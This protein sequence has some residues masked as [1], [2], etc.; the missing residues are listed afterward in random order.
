MARLMSVF[1]VIRSPGVPGNNRAVS[2]AAV[3]SFLNAGTAPGL[4]GALQLQG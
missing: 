2:T 4:P 1:S 3:S